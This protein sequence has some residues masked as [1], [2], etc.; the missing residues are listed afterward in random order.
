MKSSFVL[1][2]I[3][4][5]LLLLMLGWSWATMFPAADNWSDDKVERWSQVKDRMHSLSFLVNAPPGRTSM[6]RGPDLGA[7]KQEYEQLKIEHEQF[8]KDFQSVASRPNKISQ[9]L[10]WTGVSLLAFGVIGWYA[11]K[12]TS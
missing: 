4:L 12:Q 7:A 3:L 6:H 1:G 8:S 2:V 9:I 10:K 11:V 5:G